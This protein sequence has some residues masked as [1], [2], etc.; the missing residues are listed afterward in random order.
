[1]R[2]LMRGQAPDCLNECIGEGKVWNDLTDDQRNQIWFE[3]QKMQNEFCIYCDSRIIG[4]KRHIEHFIP[5]NILKMIQIAKIFEW[6]NLFGSCNELDHCGKY[7]DRV[8]KHYNPANHT[9]F[10]TTQ[11]YLSENLVKPDIEDPYY[12]FIYSADGNIVQSNVEEIKFKGSESIRVLNLK[13][14]NLINLRRSQI[15][16]A[17]EKYIEIQQICSNELLPEQTKI[18]VLQ[19]FVE[20]IK[21]EPF[22]CAVKQNTIDL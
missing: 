6:D 5:Q 15:E 16:L 18:E 9:C 11:H 10:D 13:S 1:M 21:N 17:K 12:Y 3:I 8:V 20:Q 19:A 2:K 7:K 4:L 14:S 22:Y